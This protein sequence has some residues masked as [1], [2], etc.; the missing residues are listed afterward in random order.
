MSGPQPTLGTDT[1]PS[2]KGSSEFP[3]RTLDTVTLLSEAA[4]LACPYQDDSARVDILSLADA[5]G[6]WE[7]LGGTVN[8]VL[9]ITGDG[10]GVFVP[11]NVTAVK[12]RVIFA[13]ALALVA[14]FLDEDLPA[15]STSTWP[16]AAARTE[17]EKE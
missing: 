9:E 6:M 5:H 12:R 13:D 3:F 16:A 7:T 2:S 10:V 14:L 15:G 4:A 11:R 17:L 8:D 1:Y